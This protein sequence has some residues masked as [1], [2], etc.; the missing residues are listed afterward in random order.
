MI[1][2][3]LLELEA[4]DCETHGALTIVATPSILVLLNDQ[5]FG[6]FEEAVVDVRAILGTSFH[7]RDVRVLRLKLRDFIIAD[8]DFCLIVHF[9][10][11]DHDLHVAA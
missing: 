9:V 3:A 2:R 1:L 10:R 7:H 8:L 5:L 11:E 6:E 4:L